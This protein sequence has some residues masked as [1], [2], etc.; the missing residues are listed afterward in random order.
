MRWLDI[1]QLNISRLIVNLLLLFDD[2][3]YRSDARS[4]NIWATESYLFDLNYFF[5][6]WEKSISK[7]QLFVQNYQ[8]WKN[9]NRL[10][11]ST[12]NPISTYTNSN[13]CSVDNQKDQN[14]MTNKEQTIWAS[15][16]FSLNFRKKGVHHRSSLWHHSLYGL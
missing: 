16:S 8:I 6:S 7:S 4:T 3:N 15:L 10:Q 5:N 9:I 13:L 2:P 11:G 1:M 12:R 14:K